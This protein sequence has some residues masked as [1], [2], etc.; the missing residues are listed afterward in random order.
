[1]TTPDSA[2]QDT[3][4]TAADLDADIETSPTGPTASADPGSYTDDGLGMGDG[5]DIHTPTAPTTPGRHARA[6][7]VSDQ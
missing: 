6:S 2:A 1:M 5:P 3:D 7:T 4:I